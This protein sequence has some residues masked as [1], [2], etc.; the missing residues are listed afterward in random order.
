MDV[1]QVVL[2]GGLDALLVHDASAGGGD[3]GRP[4]SLGSVDVVREGE[5][6]IA[7][8][9][10]TLE[11]LGVLLLLLGGERLRDSLKERLPLSPLSSLGGERLAGDEEVDRV[12]LVGSLGT[13]LERQGEDS[14]V[15][16][17]PPVVGL[18]TGETGAVNSGL[19][20]GS[21]TDDGAVESVADRVGLGVLE[22][23]GGD[24]QVGD[25]RLGEL[26]VSGEV[27][28]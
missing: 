23:E 3:V 27:I 18:V 1:N 2:I 16:T 7:R 15:V 5:E 4:A 14:R 10:D 26:W 22:R 20:S 13:L 17:E 24:D 8:A 19:L 9:H 25:G 11:L 28:E 21:E 6:G 12:G